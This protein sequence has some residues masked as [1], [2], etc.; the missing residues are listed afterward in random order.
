MKKNQIAT[1]HIRDMAVSA[2]VG[3]YSHERKKPQ[4]VVLNI[5]FSYKASKAVK[6]DD[7]KK[8]V[9]YH[10]L[11]DRI[12]RFLGKRHFILL[13]TMADQVLTVVKEDGRVVSASVTID[14]PGALSLARSV[15]VTVS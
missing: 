12:K 10:A 6:S 1:V 2:L 8:A 9:D 7:I 4:R 15:S 11:A 14:K 13:E 5:S 3:V